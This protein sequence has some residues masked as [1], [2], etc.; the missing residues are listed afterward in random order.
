MSLTAVYFNNINYF[1]DVLS[2]KNANV[3]KKEADWIEKN[4]KSIKSSNHTLA[5][6][7][8]RE[9]QLDTESLNLIESILLPYAKSY[10]E[11]NTFLFNYPI[12]YNKLKLKSSWVN[13]QKKHEF[14]PAHHHDGII[15]YVVWVKIPYSF[16]EEMEN[17]SVK[18]SNSPLA[19]SFQFLFTDILGRIGTHNINCDNTMENTS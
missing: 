18:Y 12:N 4:F 6:N 11:S 5:G 3:F 15:S 7:I 10:I 16:A 8:A 19:G 1:K 13:F 2:E 14:N 17:T 9:Y